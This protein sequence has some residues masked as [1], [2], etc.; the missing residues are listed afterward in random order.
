MEVQE[1]KIGEK[2][3]SGRLMI[4]ENAEWLY[5]LAHGAGAGM[6]HP[7]MES[8]AESFARQGIATLRFNFPYMDQGRKSPG[9]P[10]QAMEAIIDAVS[11]CCENYP[12]LRLVAG[13][14]SYGGRM[15]STAASEGSLPGVEAIIFYG[16]PL[17][18]PGK[19]SNHRAEHL[20][21]V[22]QPM[23]FLQGTRDKLADLDLLTPV[24]DQIP[25]AELFTAEG[26]DHSFNVLK[27]SGISKEEMIEGLA[28]KVREWLGRV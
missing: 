2:Q 24:V 12:D 23:L 16:F 21:Q 11:F 13:G 6:L 4:P 3:L 5:V 20:Y 7:G 26:G 14:K 10:K 18:A 8:I 19:P 27:S 1:V 15:T 25:N 9:S 22:T 28:V 17:H